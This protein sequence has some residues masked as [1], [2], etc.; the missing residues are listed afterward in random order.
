MKAIRRNF[1][2]RGPGVVTTISRPGESAEVDP[3]RY[4]ELYDLAPVGFFTL[5]RRGNILGLNK[6]AASL[7]GFSVEWLRERP[8]LVFVA[9]PDVK[10]FL[11]VL[12]HLRLIPEYHEKLDVELAIHN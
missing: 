3:R 9:Q 1:P 10:R 2:L 8:F 12:T 5:D 11:D 6:T 4:E 7:L